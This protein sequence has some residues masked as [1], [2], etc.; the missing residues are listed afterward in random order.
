MG[1]QVIVQTH[2]QN[3]SLYFF[4]E[5]SVNIIQIQTWMILK[6]NLLIIVLPRSINRHGAFSQ[7]VTMYDLHLCTTSFYC[8]FGKNEKLE[9]IYLKR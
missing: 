1:Y 9:I 5:D 4:Y 6:A 3:F 2:K 8:I 7:V